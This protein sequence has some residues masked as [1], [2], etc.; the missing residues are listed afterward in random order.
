MILAIDFDGT[1]VEDCYPEIGEEILGATEC[2]LLI[3]ERGHKIILWT[4]RCGGF[5]QAAVDWLEQRGIVP[6]SVNTHLPEILLAFGNWGG[7]KVFA[8]LYVDDR[9]L[10]GFVSWGDVAVAVRAWEAENEWVL[11]WE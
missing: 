11:P 10:G 7:A 2:L 9:N 6:D 1:I 5:L 4:C 3:Q 8:H